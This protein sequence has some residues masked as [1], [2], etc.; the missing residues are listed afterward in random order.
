MADFDPRRIPAGTAL[1]DQIALTALR[2]PA[3]A[4][5]YECLTEGCVR[6]SDGSL[7]GIVEL[8]LNKPTAVERSALRLSFE[9]SA[10][11]RGR[12]TLD[13]AV[14]SKRI[15]HW[16]Q[17]QQIIESRG[18]SLNRKRIRVDILPSLA[19]MQ[20]SFTEMTGMKF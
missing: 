3:I 19:D 13:W 16:C 2:D 10:G 14:V 20:S 17:P 7:V 15:R 12:H 1:E 11:A 8:E 18:T 6:W 9:Q 4:W 5:W